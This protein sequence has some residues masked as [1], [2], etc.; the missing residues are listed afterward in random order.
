MIYIIIFRK[1]LVKKKQYKSILKIPNINNSKNKIL[2]K[3]ISTKNL[4]IKTTK[5]KTSINS[6]N[7]TS[8]LSTKEIYL[9][10][11]NKNNIIKSK[12]SN[13]IFIYKIQ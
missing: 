5:N 2:N 9:V 4:D 6:G 3:S 11:N 1:K 10:G 8:N 13:N 12:S 7:I